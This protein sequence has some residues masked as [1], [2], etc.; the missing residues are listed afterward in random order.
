MYTTCSWG[1]GQDLSLEFSLIPQTGCLHHKYGSKLSSLWFGPL[2]SPKGW[3]TS[4]I[5]GAQLLVYFYARGMKHKPKPPRN[6]TDWWVGM[7]QRC[8]GCENHASHCFEPKSSGRQSQ[9]H[10]FPKC[11]NKSTEKLFILK[12]V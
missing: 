12:H 7:T 3:S 10:H 5:T 8:A 11:P 9:K 2:C 6:S 1:E 4:C